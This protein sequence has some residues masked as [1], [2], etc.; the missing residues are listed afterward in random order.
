[1]DILSKGTLALVELEEIRQALDELLQKREVSSS[2]V[3]LRH[4]K[5]DSETGGADDKAERVVTLRRLAV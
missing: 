1:M 5:A 4:P 2:T 3:T